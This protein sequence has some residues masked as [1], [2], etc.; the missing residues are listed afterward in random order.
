M[1]S[2]STYYLYNNLPDFLYFSDT[3]PRPSKNLELYKTDDEQEGGGPLRPSV[4]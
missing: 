2:S 1:I 4:T 3:M